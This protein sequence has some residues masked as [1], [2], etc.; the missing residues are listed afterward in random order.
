MGQIHKLSST[1]FIRGDPTRTRHWV[2]H[3]SKIS[4]CPVGQADGKFTGLNSGIT[5]PAKLLSALLKLCWLP[6]LFMQ[7]QITRNT[8]IS[9]SNAIHYS[10]V[11]MG[12]MAFQITSLA[13]AGF[14]H[15]GQ[16]EIPYLF[17]TL[18][19]P[20]DQFSLLICRIQVGNIGDYML[21]NMDISGYLW[22]YK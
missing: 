1:A 15:F 22:P 9:I 2:L 7:H 16:D 18:S 19:W 8:H 3:F 14:P 11:I 17:Q 5:C 10:D 6:F 13:I 12:R 4:T 21:Q 20:Q